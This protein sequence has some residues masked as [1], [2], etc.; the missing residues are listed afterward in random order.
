MQER[1]LGLP[2]Q[3]ALQPSGHL[4]LVDRPGLETVSFEPVTI[5]VTKQNNVQEFY[6]R[7]H[8]EFDKAI[9]GE[10][11]AKDA[12]ITSIVMGLPVLYSGLPAG[13]KST[14]SEMMSQTVKNVQDENVALISGQYDLTGNQIIGGEVISNKEIVS[15]DGKITKEGMRTIINGIVKARTMFLRLEEMNG[16]NPNALRS[17]LSVMENKRIENAS[18][19]IALPDMISVIGTMNPTETSQ[20]TFTIS[21]AMASRFAIGAVMGVRGTREERKEKLNGIRQISEQLK[22]EDGTSIRAR[23]VVEPVIEKSDLP[24]VRNYVMNTEADASTL[25]KVDDMAIDTVDALEQM[26]IIHETDNRVSKQIEMNAKVLGGL[27][28]PDHKV[29][30]KDLHDAVRTVVVA[31]A[32]A[33]QNITTINLEGTV[34][35]ITK[36]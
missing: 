22:N 18:G 23:D 32:G 16:I 10:T 20:A 5:S 7:M 34:Q 36:L 4:E 12:A 28:N 27:R 21:D 1:H 25:D 26:N 31:R 29:H 30:E 33:L 2:E 17:L 8:G 9:Y 24:I 6:Q 35:D 14:I 19:E 11:S 15:E 13:G 3:Q